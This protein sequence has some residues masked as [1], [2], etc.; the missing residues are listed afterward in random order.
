MKKIKLFAALCMAVVVTMSCIAFSACNKDKEDDKTEVKLTSIAVTTN[1]TKMEYEEGE[2]FDPTGMVVTASYSDETTKVV[3]DYT[4]DKTE[5]LAIFDSV[6][7]ISYQNLVTR[8]FITIN[9][10]VVITPFDGIMEAETHGW[11]NNCSTEQSGSSSGGANVNLFWSAKASSIVFHFTATKAGTVTLTFRIANATQLKSQENPSWDM[12][13]YDV[14]TFNGQ[15]TVLN[16]TLLG[17]DGW[18]NYCLLTATVEAKA[19]SNE[20]HLSSA[21]MASVV[22]SLNPAYTDENWCLNIDYLKIEAA[23][24]TNVLAPE[25]ASA[26]IYN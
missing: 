21:S 3:T 13:Q 9:E 2:L 12:S 18:Y 15:K 11:L 17:M 23:D 26:A 6:I 24:S 14:L 25:D 20:V 5:E 8:L 1:P 10:A 4:Y 22:N 7:T 16:G 19:G